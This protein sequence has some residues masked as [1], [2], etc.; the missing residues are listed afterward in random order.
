M[1]I[2]SQLVPN[3]QPVST[4]IEGSRQPGRNMWEIPAWGRPLSLGIY[5]FFLMKDRRLIPAGSAFCVSKLGIAVTALHNIRETVRRHWHNDFDNLA[6]LDTPGGIGMAVFHHQALTGGRFSGSVSG[7]QFVAGAPPKDVC[8]ILPEFKRGFPYLPLPISFAVPRIGSRVVCVGFGG[9]SLPDGGL[10][11][12]DIRRGRVNLLDVYEH[13]FLAVEGRVVRIFRRRFT[14]DFI[15]GPCFAIDAEIKPGM[16]GGPVFSEHGYVCG[17]I[18]AEAANFFGEP[19]TV[20]SLLYPT[21]FMNIRFGGQVGTVRLSSNRRL[22]D[23]ISQGMV[24]TDGSEILVTKGTEGDEF[25]LDPAI[26]RED[27]DCIYDDFAGFQ[28]SAG[29][30]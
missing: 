1:R 8:Y 13:K 19:S 5:P 24:I 16:C 21:L 9:L 12:D 10:F 29:R 20:V 15:G 2:I 25:F 11:L 30:H 17:V 4:D 6:A 26:H 3:E 28:E 23:L 7:L 18:S 22:I 14:N 27:A